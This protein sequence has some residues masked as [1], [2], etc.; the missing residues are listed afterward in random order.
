MQVGAKRVNMTVYNGLLMPPLLR[1][2]PGDK[3]R[4][5]LVNTSAMSTNIH[6]HGFGVTPQG[7]GDNV[8]L[9]VP[10]G[11]TP[12]IWQTPRNVRHTGLAM[13]WPPPPPPR[14]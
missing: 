6:Y 13:L 12:G 5:Q 8:F 3:V 4:L 11:A 7:T 1:V 2:Q 14:M 10:T 9:N